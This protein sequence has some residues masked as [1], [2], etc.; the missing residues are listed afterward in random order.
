MSTHI[1]FKW[2]PDLIAEFIQLYVLRAGTAEELINK[3]KESK[4]PKPEWEILKY[5]SNTEPD[6]YL[7][8][9][10]D[11]GWNNAVIRN[12]PIH[13]VKRFPDNSI[14]SIGNKFR[15]N[16]GCDLTIKRFEIAGKDI[17]VWSVEFGYW[18][19]HAIKQIPL[20]T[21]EDGIDAYEET[22]VALLST[23]NWIIKHPVKAPTS[24]FKGDKDQFKYF[25]NKEAAEE[26]ITMNKPLFSISELASNII[27]HSVYKANYI[28]LLIQKAKEKLNKR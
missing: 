21:T 9:K 25:S 2:T 18:P 3:F 17:H 16:A 5:L 20:F 8:S 23:D 19:L 24:P 6:Q 12:S 7:I 28:E 26:Y 10:M 22:R 4:Q 15:A 14:W 27:N 11:F 1:E 13:S